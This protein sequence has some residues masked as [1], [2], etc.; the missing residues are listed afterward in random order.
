MRILI[1]VIVGLSV[2]SCAAPRPTPDAFNTAQASIAAAERAGAAEHAPVELRFA[3]EK[4]AE[5]N[6]GI[7]FQQYDKSFF[8]LEQSEINSELAIEKS[9]ASK[10]RAEVTDL[11]RSIEILREELETE[12][13]EVFE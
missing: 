5:A 7:E 1:V 6:K 13:G 9:G 8:L 3:R 12:F 2:V 11:A 4:L 10:L